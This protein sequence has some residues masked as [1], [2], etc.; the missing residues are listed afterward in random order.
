MSQTGTNPDG[1]ERK[2][3][4][5]LARVVHDWQTPG[6]DSFRC[7]GGDRKDEMGLDQQA[8]NW[9]PSHQ[10]QAHSTN[11]EKPSKSTRRL[12]P[13]FVEWLMGWPI[14]WTGFEPVATGL[15]QS[16]RRKHLSVLLRGLQAELES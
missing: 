3:L 1:S 13:L 15:F 16:W 9:E 5:Q 8:R 14:G 6:T 7:R 10:A 4:D 12:N 2:R 11:G